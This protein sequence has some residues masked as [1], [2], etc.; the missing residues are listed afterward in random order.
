MGEIFLSSKIMAT[1]RNKKK[2]ATMAREIKEDPRNDQLQNSA[3][4]GIIEDCIAPVSEEIDGRVIKKLS[5]EFSRTESCILGALSKI[6]EYLLNPQ[7]RTFGH[8][9][10]PFWVHSGTPSKG[11]QEPSGGRS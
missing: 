11:N 1:S 6:D 3:A 9:P 4:P 2:L 8:S 7:V 10:E 5:R